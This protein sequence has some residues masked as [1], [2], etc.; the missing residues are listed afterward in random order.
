MAPATIFRPK[1]TLLS[2]MTRPELFGKVFSAPSFWPWRVFGKLIDGEP[3]CEPREIELFKQC[4]GRSQLLGSASHT[5][6][7]RFV[8][9][10]GRRA[11]KDRFLSGVGVWRTALAADWRKYLSPGEQAV[12]ILLGRDKK[13]AAILRRY[14]HGLLEA[15]A[16]QR[17]IRRETADVIEFKN[18]AVL[19]IASND[20]SL[21]RGRSAVAVIGSETA[22]WKAD[23]YSSNVDE[24]VVSAAEPS[25]AMCPDGGL[26][27][28]GSSVGRKRGYMFRKFRELYGNDGAEDICWF[29]PSRVMNPTLRQNVVD[30]ALAENQPKA[31]AEFLNIW[32]EDQADVFPLDAV[33]S[34]TNFDVYERPPQPSIY[35]VATCDQASGTGT[36]SFALSIQHCIYDEQRTVL[37]DVI[38][39]RKPKFVVD[40][41][42]R[43]YAELL[44]RYNI[45]EVHCDAYA[46]G[47]ENEWM[48]HGKRVVPFEFSKS[49]Y[50]AR[51]LPRVTAKRAD[52][53]N[54][55]TLRS[56][57]ISLERRVEVGREKIDHPRHA[58]AHDDVAT[59]VSAGLVIAGDRNKFDASFSWAGDTQS[60]PISDAERRQQESEQ[61]RRKGLFAPDPVPPDQRQ[62]GSY[63]EQL[64]RKLGLPPPASP[65]G[66]ARS[67]TP[68][69]AR[70]EAEAHTQWRWMMYMRSIGS[71]GWW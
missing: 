50:Y 1:I 70:D 16:L 52:F 53:I 68:E 44:T 51:A 13:Q 37:I 36:D 64:C 35:Y 57:L 22:H 54:H 5:V 49:E 66:I 61:V 59:V 25:M 6:L 9:L 71:S 21:V 42:I 10:A 7:R 48:R 23:E 40:D 28:L 69:Q 4:T 27:L 2:A 26:L 8:I 60:Q 65:H 14:C 47:F 41:V 20:A 15:P 32:R 63:H 18:G 31:A 45:N 62:E 67:K 33:E 30:A 3:L 43:E 29:A 56:Q 24:D 58:G 38:R 34:C 46:G 19:E 55:P 39:E 17:E 11:G 12:V